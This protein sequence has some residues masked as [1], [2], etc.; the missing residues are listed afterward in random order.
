[1]RD[2]NRNGAGCPRNASATRGVARVNAIVMKMEFSKVCLA[3]YPTK[4]A[5]RKIIDTCSNHRNKI[6]QNKARIC[7]IDLSFSPSFT[8]ETK[9][10]LLFIAFSYVCKTIKPPIMILATIERNRAT[11]ENEEKSPSSI[12]HY[13]TIRMGYV[14]SLCM[15]FPAVLPLPSGY[16]KSVFPVLGSTTSTA[17]VMSGSLNPRS[18]KIWTTR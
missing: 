7:L 2:K 4:A 10:F 13:S 9:I 15:S 18:P 11:I 14:L 17:S 8:L 1:M 3:L 5:Q 12:S 6:L 16:I